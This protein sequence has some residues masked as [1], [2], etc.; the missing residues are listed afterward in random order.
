M[1]TLELAGDGET[2]ISCPS[3]SPA[4]PEPTKSPAKDPSKGVNTCTL[5][6]NYSPTCAPKPAFTKVP[7]VALRYLTR[8]Q[9]RDQR[10]PINL[11][12][13]ANL[14]FY[15]PNFFYPYSANPDPKPTCTVQPTSLPVIPNRQQSHQTFP[16]AK[17]P[18][19]P[20]G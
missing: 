15:Y 14:F 6:H 19:N 16:P 8:N 2:K 4:Q 13:L 7:H 1:Y 18:L 11:S 20:E 9:F 12:Y 17:L 10:I 5:L 3:L